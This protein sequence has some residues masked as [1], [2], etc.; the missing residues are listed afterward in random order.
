[1]DINLPV[2]LTHRTMSTFLNQILSDKGEPLYDSYNFNFCTLRKFI[3][4]VGVTFLHNVVRWLLSKDIPVTFTY[5]EDPAILRNMLEPQ[6]FLDDCGFFEMYL[7]GRIYEGSS[8]RNTTVPLQ[9]VAMDKFPQWL[10]VKFIPW[11]ANAISKTP[12]EVGTFEACL[13]EIFNNV[14]DHAKE[15]SSCVFAQHFPQTDSV[16]I[17]IADMGIGIIEHIRSKEKYAHFTDEEALRNAVK[18]KFTTQ[19]TPKNRGAGLDTLVYNVVKNAGGTVY[20]YSN[21]GILISTEEQGEMVQRYQA[22]DHY[23]PGTH[24]EI[25]MDVKKANKYDFFDVEEEEFSWTE[26]Y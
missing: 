3:E 25:H 1:M 16:I 14:I 5:D 13:E 21:K 6:R 12:Q 20:I 24:I 4:P 26:D 7:D 9:D 22:A 19:S 15:N 11:F 18:K 23:Y 17:S 2:R 8:I 10:D